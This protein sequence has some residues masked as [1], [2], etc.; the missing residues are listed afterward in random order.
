MYIRCFISKVQRL[1]WAGIAHSVQGLATGLDSAGI[2][3]RWR[4]FFRTR[5]DRSWGLPSL[6]CNGYRVFPGG[7]A[8]AV[9]R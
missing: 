7:K 4:L 2:E 8:T 9:W 3:C 6:L 1:T 5:P